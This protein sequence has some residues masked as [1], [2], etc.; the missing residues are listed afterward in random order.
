MKLCVILST[1]EPE[2]VFNALRLATFSVGKG[3]DVGIFLLG[4]A[5]ELDRIES[6]QF[7]VRKQAEALLA[8]GGRIMACGTCLKL[9]DSGG[10]EICPLSTMND[11]Y[12][13]IRDADRVVS[14]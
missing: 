10:T 8:A 1:N 12:Q 3:D 4:K 5:V 13:L 9:R 7:D 14:F 6:E 2:T 11:L